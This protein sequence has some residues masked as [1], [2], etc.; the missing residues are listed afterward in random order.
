M[1]PHVRLSTPTRLALFAAVVA[2]C[3]SSSSG[4]PVSPSPF[5]AGAGGD[6]GSAPDALA[7]GAGP[8]P[9]AKYIA[10]ISSTTF[11]GDLKDAAST[12]SGL[13]GGDALCQH[14]ATAAGLTG[15]FSAWLSDAT[16]NAVDRIH[17]VPGGWYTAGNFPV[18]VTTDKAALVASG[19]A[20]QMGDEHG[21]PVMAAM[22]AD[23]LCP[24]T[25]TLPDGTTAGGVGDAGG[26]ATCGSWTSKT[27]GVLAAAGGIG[28]PS[29][30]NNVSV[31]C[32]VEGG[33]T[34]AQ[35]STSQP[36]YCFQQ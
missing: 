35:C 13:A 5:D 16:T 7:D 10:F 34:Y 20:N 33:L 17:D 32:M 24:W 27:A 19:P 36:L 31:L 11:A 29:N 14:V 21:N 26:S 8:G 15:T 2:G 6:A 23:S 1:L 22:G 3:G 12:A 30:A 9:G 25:G 4:P 28:P 18:Q